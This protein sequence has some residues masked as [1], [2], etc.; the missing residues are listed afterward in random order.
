MVS[1]GGRARVAEGEHPHDTA[2]DDRGRL[3][4]EAVPGNRDGRG[5]R[6]EREPREVRCER[7][8]HRE[9]RERDDG[10]RDQ[11]EP[12]HPS[13][14]AHVCRAHDERERGHRDGGRQR[15]ADPRREPAER[16]GPARS[17]RHPE[18]ARRRPGEQVRHGDELRKRLL[19]DPPAP[20]DVF[21]AEVPDV[22]H[23]AAERGQPEPQ[24]DA[25]HLGR[26][27]PSRQSRVTPGFQ[28][29]SSC[30][31]SAF[32]ARARMNRRSDRRFRYTDTSEP[33]SWSLR[34]PE[35]LSLGAPADRPRD[36]ERCGRQCPSRQHEAPELGQVGVEPVAV[37][38]EPVDHRL[39]DPEAPLDARRDGQVGA[40]VEE[41]VLNA[42]EHGAELARHL[43]GENDPEGGVQL[44]DR[45]VRLDAPVE[46]RD[47]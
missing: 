27:A 25:E 1:D 37:R 8:A 16:A 12:V 21:V 44:V 45:P 39:L 20:L 36:M 9:H 6:R 34:G 19:V 4:A 15:E 35:C 31:A 40:D 22:R 30:P 23:G 38:L 28:S 2:E 5:D 17:D 29:G 33:S 32:A 14:A 7:A 24:R 10:H 47:A 18:L 46:L 3:P 42:L 26:A 13:R 43:S 41:L 11:L